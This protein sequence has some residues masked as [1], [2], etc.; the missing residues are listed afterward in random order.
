MHNARSY[1]IS[2]YIESGNLTIIEPSKVFVSRFDY[3]SCRPY[4]ITAKV[5]V[6]LDWM[7]ICISLRNSVVP[8]VF[9]D[10]KTQ[11]IHTWPLSE[12]QC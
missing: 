5:R 6:H 2:G 11:E 12:P 4:S 1:A 10:T 8:N 7:H 9:Y 3:G